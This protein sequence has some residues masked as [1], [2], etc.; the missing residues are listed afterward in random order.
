MNEELYFS[1][2]D[3]T[4]ALDASNATLQEKAIAI[5]VEIRRVENLKV[6]IVE[7]NMAGDPASAIHISGQVDSYIVKLQQLLCEMPTDRVSITTLSAKDLQKD[8]NDSFDQIK[9]LGQE[10]Q[11]EEEE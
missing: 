8:R 11:D 1:L 5:E 10:E 6:N 4:V 2:Q 3:F 9:E 7:D